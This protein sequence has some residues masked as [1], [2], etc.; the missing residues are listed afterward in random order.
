MKKELKRKVMGL[1]I[2]A[3]LMVVVIIAVGYDFR[4]GSHRAETSL[5]QQWSLPLFSLNVS[6]SP[7][8]EAY[9]GGFH[10]QNISRGSRDITT[11]L[12]E[13]PGK[14][15]FWTSGNNTFIVWFWANYSTPT[16]ITGDT[17]Q[18]FGIIKKASWSIYGSAFL[19]NFT[20]NTT[21]VYNLVHTLKSYGHVPGW[22]LQMLIQVK[23]M[24]YQHFELVAL[25][26]SGL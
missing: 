20:I 11:A 18:S 23:E 15:S 24:R 7:A 3:F 8:T 19:L 21:P 2:A 10:A 26:R 17:V 22:P 5:L 6:Y 9:A 1:G 16:L 25:A 4:L 14:F 13:S 12:S